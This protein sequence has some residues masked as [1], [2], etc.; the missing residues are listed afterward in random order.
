ML[1]NTATFTDTSMSTMHTAGNVGHATHTA[2]SDGYHGIS[3][4]MRNQYIGDA[5]LMSS[6]NRLLT[7]CNDGQST[8]TRDTQ[9]HNT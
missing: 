8:T 1:G 4:T 3:Q 5:Y 6:N 2:I 9:N 7:E